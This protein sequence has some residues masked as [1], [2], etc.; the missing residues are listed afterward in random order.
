MSRFPTSYLVCV[1]VLALAAALPATAAAAT[2]AA[3]AAT[4]YTMTDLGSLGGGSSEG[5]GLLT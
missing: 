1:A 3:A 5:S 4:T 2:Y